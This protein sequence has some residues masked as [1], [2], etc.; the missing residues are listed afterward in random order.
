MCLKG[1]FIKEEKHNNSD[2]TNKV[3]IKLLNTFRT[4][5]KKTK[6]GFLVRETLSVN[7]LT[8][9]MSLAHMVPSSNAII[10]SDSLNSGIPLQWQR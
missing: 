2:R 10:N 9:S 4:V 7:I 1:I 6:R 3:N 8:S 5:E